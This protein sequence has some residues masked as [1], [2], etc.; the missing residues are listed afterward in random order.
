MRKK[1]GVAAVLVTAALTFLLGGALNTA[2]GVATHCPNHQTEAKF[3]SSGQ[4]DGVNVNIDG[5][6]VTFTDADTG[7]PVVMEF[8]VKGSNE[9]PIS[10]SPEARTRTHRTSATWSS[11]ACPRRLRRILRR[12][13]VSRPRKH[14]PSPGSWARGRHAVT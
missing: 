14:H 12:R 2:R 3:E 1:L 8:C 13:P 5:P 10:S 6:T 4:F 11:M 7:D 9:K